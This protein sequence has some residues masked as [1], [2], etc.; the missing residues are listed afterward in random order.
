MCQI[1]RAIARTSCAGAFNFQVAL[2]LDGIIQ[3][4]VL[5]LNALNVVLWLISLLALTKAFIAAC[6]VF[7][8]PERGNELH[9][10]R[11][12]EEKS[13]ASTHMANVIDGAAS[14]P[15]R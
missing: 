10:A 15:P 14:R 7:R 1:R 2:Q 13:Q 9:Q 4:V 6:S 3:L 11:G 5:V 8:R 12:I